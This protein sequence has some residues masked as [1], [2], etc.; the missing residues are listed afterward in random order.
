MW[1]LIEFGAQLNKCP[2]VAPANYPDPEFDDLGPFVRRRFDERQKSLKVIA[3]N[4]LAEVLTPIYAARR[5]DPGMS[6]ESMRQLIRSHAEAAGFEFADEAVVA[7]L[8]LGCGD[9]SADGTRTILGYGGPIE[10]ALEVASAFWNITGRTIR[11]FRK[12]NTPLAAFERIRPRATLK[13]RLATALSIFGF[14][15]EELDEIVEDLHA[16][17]E[18]RSSLLPWMFL[19]SNGVDSGCGLTFFL[20]DE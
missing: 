9:A 11:N 16:R 20:L 19:D 8:I 17:L 3:A 4:C 1:E 18:G 12:N 5:D 2:F 6:D 10:A 15:G 14:D 7:R 13:E